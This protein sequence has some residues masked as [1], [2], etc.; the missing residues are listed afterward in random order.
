MAPRIKVPLGPVLAAALL[1]TPA[2][3]MPSGN[4]LAPIGQQQERVGAMTF[5]S[6]AGFYLAAR[7]A[8]VNEDL[9]A[10]AGF[11]V[12]AL[13][14]DRDNT[15]LLEPSVILNVASGNIAR[16]VGLAED[17]LRSDPEDWIALTTLAVHQLRSGERDA[18]RETLGRLTAAGGQI[19]ELVAGLLDAWT[20]VAQ[21]RAAEGINLLDEL[22]GPRW[23]DGFTT[24]HA[25]LI[26]DFADLS[27]IADDRLRLAYERAP[28]SLRVAE[29]Y[30]RHLARSGRADRAMAVLDVLDERLGGDG[31]VEAL[32]EALSGGGDVAPLVGSALDGAAEALHGLG[33]AY[34]RDGGR[35]PAASLFQLALFLV[36]DRHF[37][38]MALAEVMESLRQYEAAIGIYRG[39][40]RQ[41]PLSRNARVQEA[42]NLNVLERNEEAIALLDELVAADPT[43]VG[44]TIVLGN[45]YRSLERF[46]EARSVYDQAITAFGEVP[47]R[48]WTLYY[49]RGIARER[50]D[51]WTGA[52]ADFRRALAYEPDNA[53]TLN[54]LGYSL[55]DRGEKLEE[56]IDMVRRAVAAEPTNGY[57]VDSLGW[58]YYRLGRYEDAVRELERA[59][60]LI[61][62][63]PVINDHLGDAYWRV[64]RRLEAM[65]QWAHARDN[66]PD[67]D[68]APTILRKLRE[69]LPDDPQPVQAAANEADA[70]GA[71]SATAEPSTMPAD[72]EDATEATD[73]AVDPAAD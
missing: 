39:I 70:A 41:H 43:D 40:P 62:L 57:I 28:D 54:Y 42:L 35:A 10:A 32:R 13:S 58:A 7:H 44:T 33:I 16:A 4:E 59:V 27:K 19:Q 56:A 22:N 20:L 73:G 29:A 6:L 45:V 31:Y 37:S 24:L 1:A 23:Y 69:G 67:E 51:D 2:A 71:S 25:G 68:I 72:A 30:A 3:A 21:G 61:P 47:D 48:H 52:E 11:Y 63:D 17:L 14:K 55:I 34:N 15:E 66:D 53:H 50:T 36:P 26:A 5:G 8:S 38:S 60:S 65:F 46:E 64:G 9:S 12:S 18:A 49:Y